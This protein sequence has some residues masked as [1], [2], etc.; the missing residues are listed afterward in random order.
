VSQT[1]ALASWLLLW[2]LQGAAPG[3]VCVHV[4]PHGDDRAA[5]EP[6]APVASLERAIALADAAGGDRILLHAGRYRRPWVLTRSPALQAD[7]TPP[8]IIEPAGDGPVVLDVSADADQAQ[9]EAE[10]RGVYTLPSTV[11]WGLPSEMWEHATSTRYTR[12]LDLAAV[13]RFPGTWARIDPHT[14]AFHTA[15]GAPLEGKGVQHNFYPFTLQLQRDHLTLRGVTIRHGVAGIEVRAC[16]NVRIEACV[17]ENAV[18]GIMV[19]DNAA[20]LTVTQCVMRDVGQGVYVNGKEVVIEKCRIIKRRGGLTP[21]VANAQ[22]D[23]GV[24]F[25]S[26]A[27]NGTV[28]QNVIAGFVHGAFFKAGARTYLVEHNTIIDCDNALFHNSWSQSRSVM[29]RNLLVNV[30]LPLDA[31]PPQFDDGSVFSQ[32]VVWSPDDHEQ[33]QANLKQIAQAGGSDNRVGDPLLVDEIEGDY[34]LLAGSAAIIDSGAPAGALG[35]ADGPV[36]R[37]PRHSSTPTSRG[38]E[39][40][41]HVIGQVHLTATQSGAVL[42]FETDRPVRVKVIAGHGN[43][44]WSIDHPEPGQS[45]VIALRPPDTTGGAWYRL[46]G[47]VFEPV[48]LPATPLP[49]AG[50]RLS[51]RVQL[52]DDS[53]S[54]P[55]E[56][57]R[58]EVLLTG[59]PRIWYIA[60]EGVDADDRGQ[61]PVHPLGSLPYALERALAGDTIR[62]APGLYHFD[63]TAL[64]RGG[65]L[66]HAPIVIEAQEPNTV[67]IDGLKRVANLI[68]L[69]DAPHVVIRNLDLRWFKAHAILAEQSPYLTVTHCRF[70]NDTWPGVFATGTAAA[71][72]RSP[73]STFSHNIVARMEQAAYLLYSFGCTVT[74]N[75]TSGLMYGGISCLWSVRDL[76]VVNNAFCFTGNDSATYHAGSME[77]FATARIDYNNYGAL[78]LA[79][80]PNQDIE[81]SDPALWQR[82]QAERITPALSYFASSKAVVAASYE[83][84]QKFAQRFLTL[85]DWQSWSGQDQHS[86]FADPRWSDPASDRW[87]PQPD[88]PLIGAGEGGATIGAVKAP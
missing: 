71:L 81:R 20:H 32:N 38:P 17:I 67:T 65:G 24:Q 86:Q 59:K 48:V 5:G 16:H 51:F 82:M 26:P 44:T 62:L 33:V 88:S 31:P 6:D 22:D 70:I 72:I 3:Q 29:R 25:Y 41:A 69:I 87:D 13:R 23:T 83:V 30:R 39:A 21:D 19:A 63:R 36:T 60:P 56:I 73:R 12:V 37:R 46:N 84:P 11:N 61:A 27:G 50:E 77:D 15:D 28:R 43:Q 78:I 14:L 68:Q 18:C 52:Q 58:G 85:R 1:T 54:T 55:P 74:H 66:P 35:L 7:A 49:Q 75:S 4:A 80:E 42:R 47:T 45:H 79:Y 53:A 9:P 2:F 10:H 76:T 57:H 64:L 8:L 34:R 40:R